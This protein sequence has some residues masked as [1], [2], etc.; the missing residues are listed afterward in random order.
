MKIKTYVITV[1]I[2]CVI[3]AGVVLSMVIMSYA[4]KNKILRIKGSTYSIKVLNGR[5][6]VRDNYLKD[7]NVYINLHPIIKKKYPELVDIVS[8]WKRTKENE[9][10][11]DKADD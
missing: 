1:I 9:K 6:D 2:A 3:V 8:D 11:M 7:I 5:I 10:L 4:T